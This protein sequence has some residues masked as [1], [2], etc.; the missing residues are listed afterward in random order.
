LQVP[1]R[2]GG[3]ADVPSVPTS[4]RTQRMGSSPPSLEWICRQLVHMRLEPHGLPAQCPKDIPP[5]QKRLTISV[6]GS[7]SSMGIERAPA[8]SPG[9][10]Q[11][12]H[13]SACGAACRL[14]S[15]RSSELTRPYAAPS[16]LP[17]CSCG[18]HPCRYWTKPKF[19]S[20]LIVSPGRHAD[21][22]IELQ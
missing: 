16:I 4:S 8:G 11:R 3:S 21:G 19:S 15:G 1:L 13:R 18:T 17:G 6:T 10:T 12:S 22:T 2:C 20:F 14:R 9:R 5:V 7:T